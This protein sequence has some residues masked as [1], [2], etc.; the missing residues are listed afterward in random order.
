MITFMS[1]RMNFTPVVFLS[2]TNIVRN[3]TTNTSNTEISNSTLRRSLDVVKHFE[4]QS[5]LN[6][7]INIFFLDIFKIGDDDANLTVGAIILTTNRAK[8]YS[9]SYTHFYGSLLY[10]IP[11]GRPYSSLEKLVFPFRYKIW[12]LIGLV[13]LI[14]VVVMFILKLMPKNKR[15]FVVGKSTSPIFNMISIFLGGAINL[16][17]VPVRNFARTIFLMW[18]FFSLVVRN[19]YQVIGNINRFF[20]FEK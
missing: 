3:I 12:S 9:R 14:A 16:Y 13:F 4:L 18:L 8:I 5:I 19:A 6:T 20:S 10:A 2:T 7:I 1:Q 11:N 17:K 15:E